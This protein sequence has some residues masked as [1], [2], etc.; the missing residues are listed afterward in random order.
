MNLWTFGA[1]KRR[2]REAKKK[3]G[4]KNSPPK[5]KP[6]SASLFLPPSTQLGHALACQ[7]SSPASLLLP[8]S[9]QTQLFPTAPL[10]SQPDMASSAQRS[11]APHSSG[12]TVPSPPPARFPSSS[13]RPGPVCGLD[14]GAHMHQSA[15]L[16]FSPIA[17]HS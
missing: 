14:P 6:S 9:A 12:P 15:T 2:K 4:E 17:A 7:R 11:L 5:E 1:K 8:R 3:K 16:S 13:R 10:I